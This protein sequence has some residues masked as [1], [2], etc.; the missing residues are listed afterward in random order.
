MLW[1]PSSKP[2]E[3]EEW[4]LALVEDKYGLH[5]EVLCRRHYDESDSLYEGFYW[6]SYRTV[7]IE[8]LNISKVVAWRPLQEVESVES[9][10]MSR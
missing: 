4:V 8:A 2:P 9:V 1:Y 10:L 3:D 7:N 5:Q 6:C